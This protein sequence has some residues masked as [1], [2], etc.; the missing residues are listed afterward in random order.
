[1]STGRLAE[2]GEGLK[3]SLAAGNLWSKKSWSIAAVKGLRN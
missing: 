1:M 2:S 3:S